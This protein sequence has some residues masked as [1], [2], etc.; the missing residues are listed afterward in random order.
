PSDRIYL[1]R[2]IE[3]WSE[4]SLREGTHYQIIFYGGRLLSHLSAQSPEDVASCIS[5]LNTNRNAIILIDSDKR[6][7]STPINE[8]KKRIQNEFAEIES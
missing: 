3:L 4:G 6:S 2:W 1:N 7:K 5:I 8:T